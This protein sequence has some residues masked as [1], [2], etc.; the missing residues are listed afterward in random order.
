MMKLLS[1]FTFRMLKKVA[2]STFGLVALV[3]IV[4]FSGDSKKNAVPASLPLAEAPMI[5][6]LKGGETYELSA[7]YVGK[8]IAGRKIKMLAY[9]GST[10]GP[11]IRV[12]EGDTA[13][14]RFTNKMDMPTLLHSHGVRTMN[15]FDGSHL[16]QLD[17]APGET[18]DYVLTFTDPGVFWYH[19]HIREDIQ[20]PMGLYGN[21]LVV[22]R[23]SAYWSPVDHEETLFLS[24][25]LMEDGDIAPYSKKYTTHALMGRFGNTLLVNGETSH[26]IKAE[27]GEVYR[28]FVTNAATVRPF[29]FRIVGARTKLV[30]GDNGRYEKETFVESVILGPSERAILDV[31]FPEVGSYSLQHRT[32]T[33]TYTLGEVKVAGDRLSP[34]VPPFDTLRIDENLQTEFKKLRAHLTR[35][36]DKVL[37]LSVAFDMA[38]IMGMMM[39]GGMSSMSSDGHMHGMTASGT[40]GMMHTPVPIEWEDTMGDMNTFST[41]DTVKWI[42]RDM[43]TGKENMDIVW[44]LKAGDVVKV[45]IVNDATSMHPMQHPIHFHGNRFVVL[46]VNDVPNDNMVWK[47]T[48]S[49]RTGDTVDIL[50]DASNPGKWLAHCHIAEHMHSGMMMEYDVK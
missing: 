38:K 41:S 9:N 49:L 7:G 10:P 26:M 8:E 48:T 28:F 6:D 50:L 3:A 32:P 25:V 45:R 4:A 21:F 2:F 24:D 23:D 13:T 44:K 40:T 39:S 31:Y 15:E 42:M 36:P 29:D 37:R 1:F 19:P 12:R 17:I 27:P 14:I 34:V 5:V 30:G 35:A 16:V 43:A 18:F 47:D 46:A 11:T 33:K 22:P 20:Q